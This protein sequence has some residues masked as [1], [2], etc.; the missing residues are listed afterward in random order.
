MEVALFHESEHTLEIQK[1]VVFPQ[2]RIVNNQRGMMLIRIP[3][4]LAKRIPDKH[5]R[6]NQSREAVRQGFRTHK[7]FEI[8]NFRASQKENFG[9][10]SLNTCKKRLSTNRYV[11]SQ[12][13]GIRSYRKNLVIF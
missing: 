3:A 12:R 7:C 5:R 9:A 13:M 8:R 10:L 2:E 1:P 6:R 11:R 4:F